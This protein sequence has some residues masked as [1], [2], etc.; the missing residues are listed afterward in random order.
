MGPSVDQ[1]T[2]LVL[3]DEKNIRKSIEIALEQ[4]GM[5]VLGAHDVSSALRTLHERIVDTGDY[6]RRLILLRHFDSES[7]Q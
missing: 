4:E 5:Q 2:I 1:P 3:D 6:S 7:Y